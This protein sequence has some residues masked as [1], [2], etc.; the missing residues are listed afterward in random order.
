MRPRSRRLGEHPARLSKRDPFLQTRWSHRRR[1]LDWLPLPPLQKWRRVKLGWRRRWELLE[2]PRSHSTSEQAR[3]LIPL[4]NPLH[5]RDG[6]RWLGSGAPRHPQ[7]LRVTRTRDAS[8]PPAPSHANRSG[9]RAGARTRRVRAALLLSPA[10]PRMDALGPHVAGDARAQTRPLERMI[11]RVRCGDL[12]PLARSR[13]HS[14]SLVVVLCPSGGRDTGGAARGR[15]QHTPR[16]VGLLADQRR[17]DG[18][19]PGGSGTREAV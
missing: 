5:L 6:S 15:L 12:Y 2:A 3:C 4:L 19:R 16:T 7:H 9:C 8:L 14:G 10:G 1:R 11:R 18:K 17:Q 13:G